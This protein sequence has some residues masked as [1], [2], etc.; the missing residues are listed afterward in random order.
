MTCKA[1]NENCFLVTIP[2]S[3]DGLVEHSKPPTLWHFYLE[4]DNGIPTTFWTLV[5]REGALLAFRV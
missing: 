5:S 4:N 2:S 1:F 3:R